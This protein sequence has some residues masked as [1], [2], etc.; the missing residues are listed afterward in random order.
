MKI[1]ITGTH[2]AGKTT[3]AEKL[4]ETLTGYTFIEEPYHAMEASGYVFGDLPDLDDFRAQLTYAIGQAE[5]GHGDI[6][7][8]RSPLDIL[9][10]LHA[11]DKRRDIRADYGR[12]QEAMTAID[13]VVFVPVEEPDRIICTDADRPGLRRAVDRIIRA[14]LEDFGTETLEVTGTLQERCSQ[15]LARLQADEA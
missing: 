12:A 15:V 11:L 4:A 8:D 3:L 7:Y 9:A 1:A 10:Y 14:W 5:A 6:I 13:L 2:R